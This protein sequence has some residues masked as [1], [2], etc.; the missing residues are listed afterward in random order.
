MPK[1]K[2]CQNQGIGIL[3]LPTLSSQHLASYG[4]QAQTIEALH[5]PPNDKIERDLAWARQERHY[6]LPHDDPNYPAQLREIHAPPIV[7]FAHG[8]ISLLH[9]QQVA[10]VGSR[11]PTDAGLRNTT[12]LAG[13]LCAQ[14]LVI[15]SGM[16]LGI[17]ACAHRTALDNE[18]PTIA[19]IATGPDLVYPRQHKSL[20][21][22][23]T[24]N[25]LL[26]SEFSCG[27]APLPYHFPQR[28]RIISALSLGVV[29]VEASL[30]SGALITARH[31]CEQN[32]EVFAVPGS[33]KNPMV[34]GCHQLIQ[35]GA[36]LVQ[37]AADI[38]TEIAPQLSFPKASETS[39]P[40]LTPQQ[41]TLLALIDYDSPITIDSLIEQSKLQTQEVLAALTA[42]QLQGYVNEK[43][44]IY[45]RL[46]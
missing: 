39:L 36:K 2:L 22:R 29:V 28:N 14:Q 26:V 27:V 13:E 45:V 19:V 25:G 18:A 12:M 9:C 11:R 33:I 37:S 34:Q 3:S 31:A 38:V 41:S 17:D 35:R 42:L 5:K 44:N 4:F 24:E 30:K 15:T 7:L 21:K 8:D 10:I 16:A 40:P 1:L 6:I 20:S 43:N 23:I 46:L 32:R